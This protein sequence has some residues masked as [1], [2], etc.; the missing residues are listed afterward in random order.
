MYSHDSVGLGH[1]RRNLVVQR[2]AFDFWLFARCARAARDPAAL[3]EVR[4]LA[5]AQG[6]RDARLESL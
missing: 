4:R 5:Q 3:A 6:L 1:A 2:E